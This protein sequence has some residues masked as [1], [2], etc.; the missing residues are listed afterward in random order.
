M[1]NKKQKFLW[2]NQDITN[3]KTKKWTVNVLNPNKQQNIHQ[4]QGE[5]RISGALNVLLPKLHLS[6][7]QTKN[8][9]QQ[10]RIG[11]SQLLLGC[12]H[13]AIILSVNHDLEIQDY[14]LRM[15]CFVSLFYL[16][17]I[18]SLSFY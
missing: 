5:Y 17:D 2:G 10:G 1:S 18:I 11:L 12:M 13:S 8:K 14:G 15:H 7:T 16:D 4:F 6:F 9:E 3:K